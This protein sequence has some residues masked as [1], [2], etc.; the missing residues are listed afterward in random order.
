[1][2]VWTK[3]PPGTIILLENKL[4]LRIHG[5][6]ISLD[7][8]QEVFFREDAMVTPIKTIQQNPDNPQDVRLV[9]EWHSKP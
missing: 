7:T 4:L 8:F 9:D 6:A 1:M 3:F 5:G 2:K